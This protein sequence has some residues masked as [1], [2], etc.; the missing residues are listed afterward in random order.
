MTKFL[1][2]E[3]QILGTSV[4]KIATFRQLFDISLLNNLFVSFINLFI[5]LTERTSIK[6]IHLK[7]QGCKF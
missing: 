4:L 1:N 7:E 5:Y 2:L 6:N 3:N